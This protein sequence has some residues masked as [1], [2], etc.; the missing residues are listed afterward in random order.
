MTTSASEIDDKDR[1]VTVIVEPILER[2]AA[3]GKLLILAFRESSSLGA[4]FR[5]DRAKS[6]T[7]T[8]RVWPKSCGP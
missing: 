6:T 5:P 8:L 4:A 1:Y 7:P 3:G 2:D